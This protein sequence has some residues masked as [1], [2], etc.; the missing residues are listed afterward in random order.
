MRASKDYDTTVARM[1]G[2]IAAGLVGSGFTYKTHLHVAEDAVII[3][4]LII[5]VLREHPKPEDK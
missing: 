2:N 3:A 1:A 5:N 4:Q